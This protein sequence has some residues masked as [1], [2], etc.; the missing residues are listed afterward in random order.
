VLEMEISWASSTFSDLFN[1]DEYL[2][3]V[4]DPESGEAAKMVDM[5]NPLG[6]ELVKIGGWFFTA[7]VIK[8]RWRMFSYERQL[9][10][11]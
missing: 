1:K 8:E 7:F 6:A 11:A 2:G 9:K 5:G 4:I 3:A 10:E